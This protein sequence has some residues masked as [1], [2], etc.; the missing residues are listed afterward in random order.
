MLFN[1]VVYNVI[2]QWVVVVAPTAGG[3]E[4]RDQSRRELTA[5][6]HAN[7]GLVMSTQPERLHRTFD[8]LTDH[9]PLMCTVAVSEESQFCIRH[10]GY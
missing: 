1:V 2:R 3:K 10:L 9:L 4:G 8:T 6:V 5:Y 7:N